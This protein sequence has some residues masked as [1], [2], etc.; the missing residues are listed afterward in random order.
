MGLVHWLKRR[1]RRFYDWLTSGGSVFNTWK[2]STEFLCDRCRLNHPNICRRPER[3]N[4]MRCPEFE[5][6]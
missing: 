3:P 5:P 1:L 2:D 6:R 4:A